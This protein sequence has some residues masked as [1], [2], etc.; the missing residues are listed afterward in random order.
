MNVSSAAYSNSLAYS[1]CSYHINNPWVLTTFLSAGTNW[2]A[3]KAA[4]PLVLMRVKGRGEGR[5][6]GEGRGGPRGEGRGEPRGREGRAKGEGGKSQYDMCIT[7]HTPGGAAVNIALLW[8]ARQIVLLHK[9]LGKWCYK[10]YTDYWL[11]RV[12]HSCLHSA[13]TFVH[14][15]DSTEHGN[16]IALFGNG[17]YS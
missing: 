3:D 10:W 6:K 12:R 2:K 14:P 8:I 16:H 17:L 13:C 7:Q 5:A 11:W 9:L 15:H 1:Q 4:F